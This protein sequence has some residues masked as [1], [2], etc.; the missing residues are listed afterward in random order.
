MKFPAGNNCTPERVREIVPVTEGGGVEFP[1]VTEKSEAVRVAPV[2]VMM[3]L[4]K[5]NVG[6]VWFP[7]KVSVKALKL[8]PSPVITKL[9]S[10]AVGNE[11]I[12]GE[13]TVAVERVAKV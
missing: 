8:K 9:F 12:S 5:L 10:V 6:V 11:V 3:L 1:K 2:T 13:V 7:V 4:A